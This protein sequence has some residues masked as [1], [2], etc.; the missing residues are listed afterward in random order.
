MKKTKVVNFVGGAGVGKSI[1]AALTFVEL[2]M[3]HIKTEFVQE[4]A[5]TLVWGNRHEELNNQYQVSCEQY[6]MIK[7]LNDVVDYIICDSGLLIGLFY[8]RYNTMNIC[9]VEKTESFIKSKMGEFN[10]VYIFLE[11]N[12]EYPFTKEGRLQDEDEAIE[13]DKKFKELLEELNLPY[14]SIISSKDS[15]PKIIEYILL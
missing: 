5:K 11:R 3:K 12:P 10:N 9:N 2:K 6:K 1:M 14:L 15:I 4:Y 7:S 13:I 8:N